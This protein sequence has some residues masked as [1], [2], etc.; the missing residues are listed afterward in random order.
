MLFFY[1]RL[2]TQCESGAIG[3]IT[4]DDLNR[5]H[6]DDLME[7]EMFVE[8]TDNY[9]DEDDDDVFDD[10]PDGPPPFAS[11]QTTGTVGDLDPGDQV[12]G[13]GDVDRPTSVATSSG[14]SGGSHVT[15]MERRTPSPSADQPTQPM[16][17]P[18]LLHQSPDRSDLAYDVSPSRLYGTSPRR[19]SGS[20]VGFMAH[21]TST[22]VP[23]YGDRLQRSVLMRRVVRAAQDLPGK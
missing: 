1:C 5:Q 21:E 22:P 23:T 9:S 4:N 12:D 18:P 10:A 17:I 16:S 20:F 13:L 14:S 6:D 2:S 3:N 8:I 7:E 15:V 19:L 11:Y